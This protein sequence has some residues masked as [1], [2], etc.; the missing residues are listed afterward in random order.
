MIFG[1]GKSAVWGRFPIIVPIRAAVGQRLIHLAKRNP[2]R[3]IQS[4]DDACNTHMRKSR[5]THTEKDFEIDQR[6]QHPFV[7][8]PTFDML[9]EEAAEFCWIADPREL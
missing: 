5:L 8:L 1:R 4:P 7:I 3:F 9:A 6:P 2:I